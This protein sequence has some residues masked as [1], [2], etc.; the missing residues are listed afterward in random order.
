MKRLRNTLIIFLLIAASSSMTAF[1][2]VKEDTSLIQMQKG[3]GDTSAALSIY[4]AEDMIKNAVTTLQLTFQVNISES[5]QIAQVKTAFT[6]QTGKLCKIKEYRYDNKT[7]E[8]NIYLSSSDA[9]FSEDRKKLAVGTITVTPKGKA[10]NAS[11]VPTA[12]KTVDQSHM[13]KEV[14][15]DELK[16]M[17][18]QIN[19]GEEVYPDP[20]TPAGGTEANVS[21]YEDV[22]KALNN[23]SLTEIKMSVKPGFKLTD[24][25]QKEIFTKLKGTDRTFII[26]VKD[27]EDF[28]YSI[29]F[30]GMTLTDADAAMDFGLTIGAKNDAVTGLLEKG[31]KNLILDFKHSGKLPGPAKVTVSVEKYYNDGQGLFLYYYNSEKKAVEPIEKDIVVVEGRA[32]MT[33]THCSVYALTTKRVKAAGD[34][35]GESKELSPDETGLNKSPKNADTGDKAP[36]VPLVIGLI[37]ALLAGGV[38]VWKMKK[39]K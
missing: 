22:I 7:H 20:E 25:Q 31:A 17:E 39:R 18:Y 29:E 16:G 4:A 2:A 14:T 8:L 28:L 26:E 19:T 38:V 15:E 30:D 11:I 10:L 21:S 24:R 36:I 9:I 35:P 34:F 13:Q 1:A 32:S 6:D 27:G 23:T 5:G 12:V 3:A 33:I 37:A